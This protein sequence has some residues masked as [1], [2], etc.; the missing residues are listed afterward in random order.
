MTHGS[1]RT[2]AVSARR[3][4]E[5]ADQQSLITHKDLNVIFSK[6]EVL[7]PIHEKQQEELVECAAT[8]DEELLHRRVVPL[9]II[10]FVKLHIDHEN[11]NHRST[12]TLNHCMANNRQF[13]VDSS[14][15]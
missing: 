7:L 2:A 9:K 12:I 8:R 1:A 4:R 10:P 3:L 6:V 5:I 15:A 13:E 11:A 14:S